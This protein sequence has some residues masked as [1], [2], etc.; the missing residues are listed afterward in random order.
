LPTFRNGQQLY[1]AKL[2]EIGSPLMDFVARP[3][4]GANASSA[5]TLNL[6][7][8]P[9]FPIFHSQHTQDVVVKNLSK[10]TP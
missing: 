1:F 5:K 10:T 3:R 7:A 6:R 4:C 8:Y 2:P 9:S